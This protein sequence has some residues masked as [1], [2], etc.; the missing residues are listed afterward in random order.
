[1]AR[2]EATWRSSEATRSAFLVDMGGGRKAKPLMTP[3]FLPCADGCNEVGTGSFWNLLSHPEVDS[4]RRGHRG[5]G[6]QG[7][8]TS[9]II[10]T[11]ALRY[12]GF[13]VSGLGHQV[14]FIAFDL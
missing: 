3:W 4:T 14:G 2:K 6:K 8:A 11:S 1:M 13:K 12:Y 9:F 7:V 5:R 10:L